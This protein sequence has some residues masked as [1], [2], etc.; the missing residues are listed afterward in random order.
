MQNKHSACS[1]SVG[2]ADSRFLYVETKWS[3]LKAELDIFHI[4]TAKTEH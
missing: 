3:I 2:Q 1:K 4:L